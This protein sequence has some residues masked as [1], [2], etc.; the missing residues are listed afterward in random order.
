MAIVKMSRFDLIV[1]ESQKSR[2]L[3]GL[4]K[5]REVDFI[6]IETSSEND[7]DSKVFLRKASNVEEL[8]KI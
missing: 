2:L 1:F 8:A 6:N 4:Q 5:F 7:E 3:K